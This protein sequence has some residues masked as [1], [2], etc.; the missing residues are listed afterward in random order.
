MS[1]TAERY[2]G[3]GDGEAGVLM[4]EHRFETAA[5]RFEVRESG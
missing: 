5:S 2:P 3:A 1:H 4:C